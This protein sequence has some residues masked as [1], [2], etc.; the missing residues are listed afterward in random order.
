MNLLRQGNRA[1]HEPLQIEF[2]GLILA[3]DIEA[4]QLLTS[5]HNAGLR[6]R[7]QRTRHHAH[8]IDRLRFEK[9]REIPSLGVLFLSDNDMLQSINGV[10]GLSVPVSAILPTGNRYLV[11]VDLG[12]GSIAPRE[13][14]VGAQTRDGVQVLSGL[15]EGDHVLSGSLFLIDG[16]CR[17]QG[18]LTTWGDKT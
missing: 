2:G 15:R 14:K 3:L 10:E 7:R 12:S 9:R 4:Q 8:R 18:V 17:N 16:E 5:S 1:F 11:F 6:H 13:I